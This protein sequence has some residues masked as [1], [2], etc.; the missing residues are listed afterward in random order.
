MSIKTTEQERLKK[1]DWVQDANLKD[2]SKE[3]YFVEKNRRAAEFLLK[4]GLPEVIKK[5][6][7]K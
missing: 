6:G 5:K 4:H 2:H 1:I 3:P 7:K